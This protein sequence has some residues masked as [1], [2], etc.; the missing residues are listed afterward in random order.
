MRRHTR[1]LV[2]SMLIAG[3]VFTLAPASGA[4]ALPFIT[5]GGRA[6]NN[7]SGNPN[8]PEQLGYGGFEARAV[9]EGAD[10]G[11]YV[12]E[13]EV[14]AR[15][16]NVANNETVVK[17]HGNVVCIANLGNSGD[18]GGDPDEDIWEIRFQI[19]RS[20]PPGLEGRYTSIFVQ[21][22]GRQDYIDESAE[23]SLLTNPNCGDAS[24]Y[25]LEPLRGQVTVHNAD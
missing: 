10:E 21:D 18:Q 15:S 25:R 3:L 4:P 24:R 20:D 8:A 22:A 7:N 17:V 13:G 9:E 14:Q 12:A 11:E 16:V 19:E 23:F 5:G 1:P 6:T 2:F